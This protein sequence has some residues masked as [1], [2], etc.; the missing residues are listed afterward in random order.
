[1]KNRSS[2]LHRNNYLKY[3]WELR[4]FTLMVRGVEMKC[5]TIFTQYF[6]NESPLYKIIM[7]YLSRYDCVTLDKSFNK[8]NSFEIFLVKWLF[9]KVA[10]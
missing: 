3:D 9:K 4:R 10:R 1:M 6:W 8:E 7:E 2:E 5:N